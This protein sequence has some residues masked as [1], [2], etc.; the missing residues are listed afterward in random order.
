MSA[1]CPHVLGRLL[2][3]PCPLCS[4]A[5]TAEPSPA[6]IPMGIAHEVAHRRLNEV[7]IAPPTA[8]AGLPS[9]LPAGADVSDLVDDLEA[10]PFDEEAA[11]AL[12]RELD[13]DA[14]RGSL[15]EFVKL[16]F[17]VVQ[18][19]VEIEWGPHLQAVCDH[20]QWQLEDRDG[21]IRDKTRR[22]KL[23]CQ[24][25]LINIPPRSLKTVCLTLAT[26]W[27]WLRWPT[28]KIMYLSANPRVASNSARMAR[29]LIRSPW[30]QDLFRP[31]W[32]AEE[33]NDDG[34]PITSEAWD[35]RS[36]QDALN[37]IGNTAG[38]VRISRGL[39]STVVGEGSGWLLVDDPHDV[40][41]S[42]AKVAKAVEDYD[43]AI[44][45]RSDDP[46]TSIRTCLM[47]RVRKNDLSARWI[48][49]LGGSLVHVRLPTE[50]EA[51]GS[52]AEC[53]CGTCTVPNV[54]GFVDWRKTEGDVLHERFTTEFL[55][56][57]KKR[58]Q[59]RYVGQ[60]QQRP[61]EAGGQIF[62][63]GWWSWFSLTT[64]Q[65]A[66]RPMGARLD[67]PHLVTRRRDG[68]LDLDWVD[69]S[70]DATGGST[71]D[72]ASNL[73][74]GAIG[75][76]GERRFLL[77][78]LTPG[79][80]TWLQTMDHVKNAVLTTV[81]IAGKQPRLTVLVEKKAL[82]QALVEQL[83]KHIH[84]GDLRYSD[85]TAIKARVETYEP[86]GKG[87]KEDRAELMEPDLAAGLFHL[88]DG[89]DANTGPYRDE[90]EG[91]PKSDRDDRVDYT[92]QCLDHHRSSEAEWVTMFRKRR[93]E[94]QAKLAE[95]TVAQST[96]G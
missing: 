40:R 24:N 47:Q 90:V 55:T 2:G 19:G 1:A 86:T 22:R 38:G 14:C 84:D 64:A 74:M 75:G 26:V 92:S 57:E 63:V 49:T 46:R 9:G 31:K 32:S 25:L 36:D 83:T 60:H 30:F 77:R 70:I 21:V 41:D 18:P 61:L 42:T 59:S 23:K 45:N 88:L 44:H 71:S 33:L 20:V 89:D 67:P 15:S 39:S 16:A 66:A 52:K 91:F 76:K 95:I 62:K 78:D 87:D 65:P 4:G 58:L 68:S 48:E 11:E 79:P 69:I 85:G 10:D 54:F 37:S 35:I 17:A 28:L 93:A 56:G 12:L 29:D 53:T 72:T 5:L 13:A 43:S 34:D 94:K 27:A 81:K 6:T 73:G 96:S 7:A 50:Y 3:G 8:P 51:P 82:G 80:A